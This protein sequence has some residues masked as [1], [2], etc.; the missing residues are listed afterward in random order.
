[1]SK[2]HDSWV[3]LGVDPNKSTPVDL[4][5][6]SRVESFLLS[7]TDPQV[8]FV[9]KSDLKLFS[10]QVDLNRLETQINLNL[11]YHTNDREVTA[12]FKQFCSAFAK[13]NE[14]CSNFFCII[15]AGCGGCAK[16]LLVL[17]IGI[18]LSV[19]FVILC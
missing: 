13:I 7:A 6:P 11:S 1:M 14:A 15:D 18:D 5:I 2:R 8:E 3:D 9:Q 10:P 4:G 16:Q 19:S 12:A 17:F